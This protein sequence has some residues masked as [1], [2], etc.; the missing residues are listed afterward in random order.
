MYFDSFVE[1]LIVCYC[2]TLLW[3]R[4]ISPL[5]KYIRCYELHFPLLCGRSLCNLKIIRKHSFFVC[6][7]SLNAIWAIVCIARCMSSSRT[8][9]VAPVFHQTLFHRSLRLL[10]LYEFHLISLPCAI[11]YCKTF[12]LFSLGKERQLENDHGWQRKMNL[13]FY[14][15]QG[16]RSVFV[17]VFCLKHFLLAV[18]SQS[19][20]RS[21][22]RIREVGWQKTRRR[23]SDFERAK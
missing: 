9:S 14:F 8:F 5:C 23:R 20:S 21:M 16:G 7:H 12:W 6:C 1:F 3:R 15:F 19:L 13:Y 11:K 17:W 22:E 18:Q 4:K 2:S 10:L